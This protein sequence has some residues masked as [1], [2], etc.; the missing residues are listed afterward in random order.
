MVS[1]LKHHL[2]A[3]RTIFVNGWWHSQQFSP[4][5]RWWFISFEQPRIPLLTIGQGVHVSSQHFCHSSEWSHVWRASLQC[6]RLMNQ[7]Q[8]TTAEWSSFEP[9]MALSPHVNQKYIVT[10]VDYASNYSECLLTSDI[11]SGCIAKWLETVF[12]W[13]G[14]LDELI[15]DN[16]LQF[17]SSILWVPQNAWDHQHPF[18]GL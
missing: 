11:H 16:E 9:G 13:F 8:V 14:N 2:V 3:L 17:T 7:D 5:G 18:S 15:S 6:L 1:I 12:A 4:S 10:V